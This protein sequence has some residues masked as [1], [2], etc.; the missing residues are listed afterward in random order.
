MA[1]IYYNPNPIKNIVGDCVIRAICCLTGSDWEQVY[2]DVC[3]ESL[4]LYDM[5]SSNA[6]WGSFLTKLGYKR[7]SIPNTCPIC[8]SVHDFCFDHPVGRYLLATGTHVI[9]VIDGNYYDTWDSG[10]EVPAYYW[11]KGGTNGYL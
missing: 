2:M 8:Y 7:T 4:E 3:R 11:R 6:V 5:P 10:D 9:T 1:Y